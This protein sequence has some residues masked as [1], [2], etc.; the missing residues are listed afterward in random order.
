MSLAVPDPTSA[1]TVAEVGG[2]GVMLVV[3]D[4][5]V[6][7]F[8]FATGSRIGEPLT[9]HEAKIYG[10]TVVPVGDRPLLV[11]AAEDHSV[12]VWDL[13]ARGGR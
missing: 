1:A 4:R 10:M 5:D 11:A 9:G 2:R 13:T 3:D 7:M 8:D 12:R 6:V